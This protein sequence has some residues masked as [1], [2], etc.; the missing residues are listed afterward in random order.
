MIFTSLL[1]LISL[2]YV[3]YLLSVALIVLHIAMF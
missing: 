3:V 2:S 1:Y